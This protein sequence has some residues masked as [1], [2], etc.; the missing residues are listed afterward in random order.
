MKNNKLLNNLESIRLI[1]PDILHDFL[2]E[3]YQESRDG[4]SAVHAFCE[5]FL[6]SEKCA[7]GSE[8]PH[9]AWKHTYCVGC[10]TETPTIPGDTEICAVCS[11]FLEVEA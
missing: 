2:V 11:Q 9:K 10:E 1:N 8:H 6:T 4:A 5:L 3:L 7:D